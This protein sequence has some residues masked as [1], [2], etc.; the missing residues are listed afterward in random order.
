[1]V[2]MAGKTIVLAH[3]V[4]G[5]GEL[6]PKFSPVHYFNGV[7]TLLRGQGHKVLEPTVSPTGAIKDRGTALADA[8]V[9]DT[10]PGERVHIIAHSMGGLDARFAIAN[11]SDVAQRVAT[12]VTIGTPHQGS[13]VA[14]A[15]EKK[16]GPLFDAIPGPLRQ[17]LQDFAKK[18]AGALHDLTTEGGKQFDRDTP[19]VKSVRYIE[20]AGDAAKGKE[21]I[22]FTLA[23]KIG[24]ITNEINDGVVTRSSALRADH[25]HLDD[26]PVDHGGEIGWGLDSPAPLEFKVW[27]SKLP[28]LSRFLQLPPHLARY[29]AIVAML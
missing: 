20:V 9:K 5:F 21:S 17:Q 13:P 12:L 27:L 18:N 10:Q 14:S 16:T 15:I 8:I 29:E 19:D 23:A 26:W 28:F 1:M 4:L 2:A 3:G 24:S 22:L 25:Q 11:R 7:A 6:L